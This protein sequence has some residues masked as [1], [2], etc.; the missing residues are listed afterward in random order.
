MK[1]IYSIAL[2]LLLSSLYSVC[3]T[4]EDCSKFSL[5]YC[6]IKSRDCKI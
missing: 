3:L 4:L 1:V 2:I 6:K 5:G